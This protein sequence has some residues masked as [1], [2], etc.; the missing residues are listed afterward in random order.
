MGVPLSEESPLLPLPLPLPV[1][2]GP[3]GASFLAPPPPS[4]GC[5]Q[6][7][8]HRQR[9]AAARPAR[10]APSL[11]LVVSPGSR[12]DV[13]RRVVAPP[14]VPGVGWTSLY[15]SAG[16]RT[17]DGPCG[18]LATSRPKVRRRP[19]RSSR[20][21]CSVGSFRIGWSAV[22]TTDLSP[23]LPS[24][25]PEAHASASPLTVSCGSPPPR[26]LGCLFSCPGLG[27]RRRAEGLLARPG[28][29]RRLGLR[30]RLISPNRE[31]AFVEPA[32]SFMALPPPGSCHPREVVRGSCPTEIVR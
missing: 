9:H 12:S 30:T 22:V 14:P 11:S 18:G 3:E 21:W 19:L 16:V 20:Q 23:P 24:C 10:G 2:P 26:S 25:Y 17:R 15:P 31:P 1:L 4:G 8:L 27:G 28:L 13:C 5:P 32:S 29:R 6:C 7:V